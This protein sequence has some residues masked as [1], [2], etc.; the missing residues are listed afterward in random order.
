[1]HLAPIGVGTSPTASPSES[2][3]NQTNQLLL[4]AI[5]Q[6]AQGDMLAFENLYNLTSHFMLARVR[7]LVGDSLAEDVL[8]DVYL[9]AWRQLATFDAERGEPLAW[10]TTIGRSRALDCLRRERTC[11][12]GSV[13]APAEPAVEA[14]H[15]EGPAELLDLAQSQAAVC[16]GMAKLSAKERLVIGMAYFADYTQSEISATTGLPLGS[17][18]SLMTRSQQKLRAALLPTSP[19][20]QMA[21]PFADATRL[22][23][24]A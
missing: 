3:R 16:S 4:Q 14:S 13:H 5:R 1:M 11:H 12:G 20:L 24:T 22:T 8:A 2:D 15:R 21:T 19:S 18:K 10:L 17:V 23:S 7:R 9:Q 6:A